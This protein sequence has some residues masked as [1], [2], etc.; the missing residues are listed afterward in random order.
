MTD[1]CVLCDEHTY[2]TE[3]ETAYICAVS[4][5]S[6][7]RWAEKGALVPF[8]VGH[9]IGDGKV[10]TIRYASSDVR[11][12]FNARHPDKDYDEKLTEVKEARNGN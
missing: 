10:G 5:K 2:L 8:Y 3:K 12:I 4:T 7:R 9:R 11:Q 6:I 1:V